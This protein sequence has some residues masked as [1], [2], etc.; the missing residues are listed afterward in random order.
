MGRLEE[1]QFTAPV[2]GPSDAGRAPL[3]TT[4]SPMRA[5]VSQPEGREI[6]RA[7]SETFLTASDILAVTNDDDRTWVFA[8]NGVEYPVQPTQTGW[9]PF[10]ALADKLGD[11]RSMVGQRVRFSDGHGN[12]GLVMD[13]YTELARLFGVYGIRNENMQ[14]TDAPSIPAEKGKPTS[15][16]GRAPR[17]RVQTLSGTEIT[18]PIHRPDMVALPVTDE[19]ASKVPADSRRMADE[20]REEVVSQ[21]KEIERLSRLIERRGQEADAAMSDEAPVGAGAF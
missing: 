19:E 8:W 16:V 6:T 2:A 20:L 14:D 13:R 12:R 21:R 9:V 7:A 4:T 5:H 10:P 1:P 15:L 18:F 3:M 17:V 11:P